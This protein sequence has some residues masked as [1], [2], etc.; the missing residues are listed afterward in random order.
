MIKFDFKSYTDIK[1]DEIN[2][3]NDKLLNLNTYFSKHN[4]MLGWY[5][6]DKLSNKE[7]IN[8][9][10]NKAEYI[11]NN[12]D[13][14]LVI[15]IGGS[16]L[17][18]LSV[19]E[20]LNPYFYNNFNRPE[21]YFVGTSLSSEY[22]NALKKLIEDKNIIINFISKSGTTF[23]SNIA[24]NLILDLMKS[25]YNDEDIKT[26]IIFTTGNDNSDFTVPSNIPG[27]FSVF[28]PVGLLPIAVSGIDIEK[29]L[30]GAKDSLSNIDNQKKYACV[31]DIMNKKGKAIEAFIEYEQKLYSLTKW[32]KQ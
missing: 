16:Y 28:T 19:I 30:E 1:D 20:A 6:L 29:L 18:A 15:G 14:F 4:D 32:L 10:K 2:N 23:E 31:R 7:L 11:K 8:K 27:R 24:Y 22:I 9:I 13:V 12:C 3:Y 17:G 5:D 21:I 26:R 25:K